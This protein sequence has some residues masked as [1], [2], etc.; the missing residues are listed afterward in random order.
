M[1]L[2]SYNHPSRPGD[3]PDEVRLMLV[4]GRQGDAWRLIEITTIG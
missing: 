3:E 2:W 1:A 4:L